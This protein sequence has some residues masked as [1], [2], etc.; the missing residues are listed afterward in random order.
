M[1]KLFSALI[2]FSLISAPAWSDEAAP[3]KNQIMLGTH[4]IIIDNDI[5]GL[6]DDELAGIMVSYQRSITKIIA[7]RA[8]YF[9][10]EHDDYPELESKGIEAQ[11]LFG[12][13]FLSKGFYFYG[14][15]GFFNETWEYSDKDLDL[16]FNG[17]LLSL[18]LGYKWEHIV[19]D[20]IFNI[21]DS[22]DYED[23]LNKWY[24]YDSESIDATAS[25]GS[26]S[27]GIRF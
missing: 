20:F 12:N 6:K 19:L 21:R 27:I 5:N 18:G 25:S 2:L 11:L 3:R 24:G 23:K 16:D 13:N 1:K 15:L 17:L 9:F 10:D 22:S 26:F 4:A 8:G 7:L 14:G